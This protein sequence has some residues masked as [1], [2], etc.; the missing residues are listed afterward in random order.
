MRWLV[1]FL[2]VVALIF[3]AS[4][5]RAIMSALMGPWTATGILQDGSVTH[6]WFAPDLPRPEWVP[7]Y[8][9]ASVVQ[10]SKLTSVKAPSGAHSLDIATRASLDEVKR[11]YVEQLAA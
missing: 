1:P 11:F 4:H 9:G 5:A 7:V 8:P 3:G 6:M 2:L 10:A